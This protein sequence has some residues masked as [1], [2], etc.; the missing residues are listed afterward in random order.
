MISTPR[1]LSNLLH[2]RHDRSLSISSTSTSWSSVRAP[3]SPSTSISSYDESITSPSFFSR[4]IP[5]SSDRST[6]AG[7]TRVRLPRESSSWKHEDD[8]KLRELKDVH[9]LGWRQIAD[10]FPGRTSNACQ[11]RWR[12]L[13][14]GLARTMSSA[15]SSTRASSRKSSSSNSQSPQPASSDND[16]TITLNSPAHRRLRTSIPNITLSDEERKWTDEEDELLR[17][18]Q[19][20]GLR[21][22]ELSI[23]LPERPEQQIVDRLK[24]LQLQ[25]HH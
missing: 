21:F 17:Y 1:Q 6:T 15:G 18:S 11:F 8:D 2:Y 7:S 25:H 23:L 24:V 4:S 19:K 16:Q 13:N 20:Q 5:M 3:S 9:N 12:R 14:S 22:D 10:F